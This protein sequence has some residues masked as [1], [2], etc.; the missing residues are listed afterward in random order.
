MQPKKLFST[1]FGTSVL[2]QYLAVKA[3][4]GL[5]NLLLVN[6]ALEFKIYKT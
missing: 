6:I 4:A 5:E 2:F 1:C 3:V